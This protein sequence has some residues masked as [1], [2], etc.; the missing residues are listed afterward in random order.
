MRGVVRKIIAEMVV[1]ERTNAYTSPEKKAGRINGSV[2]RRKVAKLSAP[3]LI[4]ASSMT[5]SICDSDDYIDFKGK[6]SSG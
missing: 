5:G 3:R 2:T 1:I 4:D 6:T